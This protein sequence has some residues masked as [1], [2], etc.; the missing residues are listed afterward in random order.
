MAVLPISGTG[1]QKLNKEPGPSPAGG[2]QPKPPCMGAKVRRRG[3]PTCFLGTGSRHRLPHRSYRSYGRG[4]PRTNGSGRPRGDASS[5]SGRPLNSSFLLLEPVPLQR[6]PLWEVPPPWPDGP[7][8]QLVRQRSGPRGVPLR[9]SGSGAH[10]SG[11]G[12]QPGNL[13]IPEW[14]PRWAD[15]RESLPAFRIR[16]HPRRRPERAG[17]RGV[18]EGALRGG[19]PERIDLLGGGAQPVRRRCLLLCGGQHP[20]SVVRRRPE[21]ESLRGIACGKGPLEL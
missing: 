17:G 16:I 3:R 7:G 4:V 11:V 19:H 5:F 12:H 13:G 8:R 21:W 18:A 14:Y 1:G 6:E 9:I 15:C 20:W 10:G 2:D